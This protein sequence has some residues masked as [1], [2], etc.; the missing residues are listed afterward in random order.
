MCKI[1]QALCAKLTVGAEAIPK[2]SQNLSYHPAAEIATV[3]APV[4]RQA[5]AKLQPLQ[6]RPQGPPVQHHENSQ[7]LQHPGNNKV[8][9]NKIEQ[10]I[11]AIRLRVYHTNSTCY[12]HAL[13]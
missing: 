11:H 5:A 13:S 8:Q 9:H 1:T 4:I 6:R 2:L 10:Q 7:G 12:L 3:Q